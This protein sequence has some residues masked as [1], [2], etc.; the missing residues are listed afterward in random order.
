MVTKICKYPFRHSKTT[1]CVKYPFVS[2]QQ[3]PSENVRHQRMC[4]QRGNHRKNL[5]SGNPPIPFADTTR[6]SLYPIT[7]SDPRHMPITQLFHSR[8]FRLVTP[9]HRKRIER[10][11]SSR[12]TGLLVEGN[13][14]EA[15]RQ[16]GPM[17]SHKRDVCHYD[18]SLQ[19]INVVN[20]RTY[21]PNTASLGHPSRSSRLLHWGYA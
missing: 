11:C 20:A 3:P 15:P 12:Q 1:L 16:T 2:K 18:A 14:A 4:M 7:C 21:S 19:P 9:A 17:M 10:I 13:D 5:C 6:F 8:R